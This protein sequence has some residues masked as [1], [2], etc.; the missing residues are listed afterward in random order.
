MMFISLFAV[1]DL[2]IACVTTKNKTLIDQIYTNI[3]DR[4][5]AGTIKTYYSD[6]D[7][8]FLN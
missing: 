8:I 6:H 5:K 4:V 3:Q 1:V 2:Y 7:Q